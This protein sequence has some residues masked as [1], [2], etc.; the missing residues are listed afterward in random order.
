MSK[1]YD[2]IVIGVGGM[3]S[4]TCYELAARGIRV[5]GLEKFD[6]GHAMGSS[7]GLTRILRLAYFEGS[8]YVPLI[9]RAHELWLETGRKAGERLLH[10]TGA[11]IIAAEGAGI[12]EEA[13]RA[14]LEHGVDHGML[15]RDEVERRFPA[16]RLPSGHA[17]LYQPESGFVASERAIVTH[18]ALALAAGAEI[19][20]REPMLD[21]TPTSDGGVRVRTPKG[22]YEAGRLILAPGPWIGAVVPGLAPAMTIIRQTQGWF[23]PPRPE[24]V[25]MGSFPVFTM[26]VPE[27]HFYGFPVWG[28]PGFKL[29][30]PHYGT[31]RFDPDTPT[32][33][34]SPAHE[35]AL[36]AFLASYIPAA[37]GPT[38]A[39]R[40]CLYTMTPDEHFVIDTLPDHPQ[41]VVAS[42]CS[43]HGFKFASVVGEILA[44][45]ATKGE[46]RF[47]L[48]MFSLRRLTE[49]A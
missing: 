35:A 41:V 15:G 20:A 32:R 12:V 4:A 6:I 48:S 29:G 23:A 13:Q 19:R 8:N 42:P 9:R 34:P 47:D 37:A 31:D 49:P 38:L 7:H 40:A 14:C 17:A 39:L 24:L 27:G 2:V 25:A 28:H 46:S 11:L 16:F 22:D 3:G 26:Q 33:E 36:Q 1:V 45:L 10:V 18:V 44:D 21:W 30:A 43:G 5:L